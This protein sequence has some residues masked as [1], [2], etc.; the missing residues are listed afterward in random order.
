[1]TA[2]L[3]G[4]LVN[5]FRN[6]LGN[7]LEPQSNARTYNDSLAQGHALESCLEHFTIFFVH[8]PAIWE[9]F[10]KLQEFAVKSLRVLESSARICVECTAGPNALEELP[11]HFHIV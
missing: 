6:V 11:M 3:F 5:L 9:S 8:L 10:L 1:M 7:V 4:M 2:L